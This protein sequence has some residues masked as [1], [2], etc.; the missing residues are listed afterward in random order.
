V[1]QFTELDQDDQR[2]CVDCIGHRWVPGHRIGQYKAI[3]SQ[4]HS[5]ASGTMV[6]A[7]SGFVNCSH[8]QLETLASNILD[9]ITEIEHRVAVDGVAVVACNHGSNRSFFLA[10]LYYQKHFGLSYEEVRQL[11][12]VHRLVKDG[13]LVH[14]SSTAEPIEFLRAEFAHDTRPPVPLTTRYN[15]ERR[16]A[17]IGLEFEALRAVQN[18]QDTPV[19]SSDSESESEC[20]DTAAATSKPCIA[21]AIVARM[22]GLDVDGTATATVSVVRRD[23]MSQTDPV[24]VT[25]ACV[26]DACWP[27]AVL[28]GT[29]PG[30]FAGAAANCVAAERRARVQERRV[31]VPGSRPLVLSQPAP[32]PLGGG[33]QKRKNY[34]YVPV[35]RF[36]GRGSR[37]RYRPRGAGPVAR[38]R[39]RGHGP[40]RG[41]AVQWAAAAPATND[42]QRSLVGGWDDDRSDGPAEP[43][44]PPRR[45]GVFASADREDEEEEARLDAAAARELEEGAVR[46]AVARRAQEPP[47]QQKA[48][49]LMA[50]SK[51]GLFKVVGALKK[52]AGAFPLPRQFREY[53]HRRDKQSALRKEADRYAE[54][55][56]ARFKGDL[57]RCA[58]CICACSFASHAPLT[59]VHVLLCSAKCAVM[60]VH[61]ALERKEQVVARQK[62]EEQ[63]KKLFPGGVSA[64]GFGEVYIVCGQSCP[65]TRMRACMHMVCRACCVV[66][67][68]RCV[69]L[70]PHC[71]V[72]QATALSTFRAA[73]TTTSASARS[74]S[75]FSKAPACCTMPCSNN[76]H[77]ATCRSCAWCSVANV[78]RTTTSCKLETR[79]GQR[80]VCF[81]GA[82]ILGGRALL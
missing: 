39:G 64:G 6:D 22:Q 3:V 66:H 48:R 50:L 18:A 73:S 27:A 65:C 77:G 35:G 82:G 76:C 58:L 42:E 72:Q 63:Q 36:G 69:V 68:A 8:R 55:Y 17:P 52:I 44:P 37:G 21:D 60:D 14:S 61:K 20:S 70:M 56:E 62:L 75:A 79:C 4:Q 32:P 34:L 43:V 54:Y 57:S 12:T 7:E 28:P 2:A 11:M 13:P 78:L 45:T 74:A 46:G 5:L 80:S 47:V 23:S 25:D 49:G 31:L 81:R 9:K 71:V 1:A 16:W 15:H 53:K 67:S 51:A 33:P 26:C 24:L 38:G 29:V 10:N 19:C 41:R 30:A 40:G 59:S